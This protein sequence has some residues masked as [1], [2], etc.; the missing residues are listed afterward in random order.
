MS[1]HQIIH[2]GA[3]PRRW[4]EFS[5]LREEINKLSHPARPEVNW[6]LIESLSL[7]LFRTN[8]VDLQTAA[9]YTLARTHLGG[10]SGFT[11]GCEMMASLISN[12]WNELWPEQLHARGEMLEWFNARVGN[13][14]RHFSY[15]TE[16][17]RMVYRAE[18][19]L[20]AITDKLEQVELKRMPRIENLLYFVQSTAQKLDK[21]LEDEKAAQEKESQMPPL[22]FIPT[23]Q[24]DSVTPPP[25]EISLEEQKVTTALLPEPLMPLPSPTPPPPLPPTEEIKAENNVVDDVDTVNNSV[26]QPVNSTVDSPV[27]KTE[28]KPASRWGIWSGLAL[29]IVMSIGAAALYYQF[30]IKPDLNQLNVIQKEFNESPKAWM[31]N[32]LLATYQ[33]QMNLLTEHGPLDNLNTAGKISAIAK[34]EWPD[35]LQQQLGTKHW[36]QLLQARAGSGAPSDNYY[37]AKQQVQQLSDRLLQ[38]EQQKGSVTISY[39]KSAIYGIQQKL[40]GDVPLEELLRQLALSHAEGTEADPALLKQIDDRFNTLLSRYYQTKGTAQ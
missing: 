23:K 18:R 4:P 5:A 25:A 15:K 12:Q 32:P 30:A 6:R 2:T 22:V 33:Q 16:D 19:A 27:N 21:S 3:D 36:Q 40:D 9:Y 31:A 11:E 17:L 29:G 26:D 28:P 10:L 20:K 39:L 35:D 13:Y 38:L 34:K 14:I 1:E 8:G 24:T 37:Q 7:S